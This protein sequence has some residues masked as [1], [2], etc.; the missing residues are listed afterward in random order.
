GPG[1]SASPVEVVDVLGPSW[2]LLWMRC[3]II[4]QKA[5]HQDCQDFG[6]SNL[7]P[8]RKPVLDLRAPLRVLGGLRLE[9]SRWFA[10]SD[11]DITVH[12]C[13]VKMEYNGASQYL[14][15]RKL[16]L[17]TTRAVLSCEHHYDIMLQ[18]YDFKMEYN[19][20]TMHYIELIIPYY[21]IK[22]RYIDVIMQY[23]HIKEQCCEITKQYS[24]TRVQP[25]DFQKA[26]NDKK[27]FLRLLASENSIQKV[28]KTETQGINVMQVADALRSTSLLLKER[29]GRRWYDVTVEYF[30]VIMYYED[31]LMQCCGAIMPYYDCPVPPLMLAPGIL[32]PKLALS[33]FTTFHESIC[34]AAG[35]THP[36]PATSIGDS[37]PIT[38]RD[39]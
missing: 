18:Y 8:G 23:Y 38:G 35:P 34:L 24:N 36:T 22:V 32:R 25:C 33:L 2:A 16:S 10:S 26:T 30:D 7:L 19:D 6:R 15:H 20:A 21:D 31:V 4:Q 12:Y 37:A 1:Q 3:G 27:Q 28:L 9:C 17:P 11:Y 29:H 13:D 5:H 39:F 14:T